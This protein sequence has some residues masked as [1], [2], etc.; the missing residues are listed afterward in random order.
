MN[1]PRIVLTGTIFLFGIIGFTGIIK[2]GV[3]TA[4]KSKALKSYQVQSKASLPK[5]GLHRLIAINGKFP[6]IDR[7]F[8]LFSTDYPLPFVKV[9]NYSSDV[10]WVKG[11]PAW[12]SDYA[13]H[14]ATSNH[15]IAR[16]LAQ[17]AVYEPPVVHEGARFT[18]F[19]DRAQLKFFLVV[20][21]SLCRMGLYALDEGKGERTFL[22]SYPVVLG[23]LDDE[24]N[25]LTPKGEFLLGDQVGIYKK[26]EMG[27]HLGKKVEMLQV[28]GSRFLPLTG[29]S[30]IGIQ[31]GA[32]GARGG[33]ETEG[34]IQMEKQD[35]EE[36]FAIVVTKPTYVEIVDH[37][38]STYLPG[39]EVVDFKR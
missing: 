35:I 8:Q 12:I 13:K 4:R 3:Y 6:P 10:P 28:F 39:Q 1:F 24:G 23:K 15:F 36:L 32:E 26:G 22:K 2:K 29:T 30:G 34:C 11:R 18:L 21:R 5:E 37:F 25:S 7:V 9:V 17:K 31:G 27:Y 16:S 19:D 20:D 38:Q 33:Y 14:F